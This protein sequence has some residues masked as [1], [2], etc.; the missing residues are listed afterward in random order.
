[1]PFPHPFP[2]FAASVEALGL[3]LTAGEIR[4]IAHH[5]STA[6]SP[7]RGSGAGREAGKNAVVAIEYPHFAR[8]VLEASTV[9][10][11]TGSGADDWGKQSSSEGAWW[12]VIPQTAQKCQK[13]YKRA[14]SRSKFL[15]SLKSKMKKKGDGS[16]IESKHFKKIISSARIKLKKDDLEDL[17]NLLGGE[18][19]VDWKAFMKVFKAKLAEGDKEDKESD[20]DDDDSDGGSS[21]DDGSS[22]SDGSGS[23]SSGSS[24]KGSDD[25]SSAPSGLLYMFA[26]AM[27]RQS[28]PRSWLDH[29]CHIFS[30]SDKDERGYLRGSAFH[31][32]CGKV[33]V[34]VSK[35]QFKTLAKDLDR[36][37]DGNVSYIEIL[38][39]LLKSLKNGGAGG[40]TFLGDEREI[41][42]KILDAMGENP[43]ARRRWLSKLRKHFFGL[44]NFRSGTM[45]GPKLIGVLRD[46]GV[47]LSRGEE[48]RLL[49]LLATMDDQNEGDPEDVGG[50]VSYRELLR[51]CA[52]NA[53]KWY[54]QDVDLAETLRRALRDKMRK[55]SFVVNLKAAFEEFDENGDGVVS[56]R[57]FEKACKKLGMRLESADS[58][59]L[60]EIL[61]LDGS[62]NISYQDF[63]TFFNNSSGKSSWYECEP[64]I[65][66]KMKSSVIK[67]KKGA[68]AV[69]TFRDESVSCD[70]DSNGFCDVRDLRKNILR[71][72]KVKLSEKVRRIFF[73]PCLFLPFLL[74][75]NVFTFSSAAANSFFSLPLSR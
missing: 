73:C 48:G 33:G 67:N 57:E 28:D 72:I 49:E 71:T 17:V 19:A 21:S 24:S 20:S 75:H 65:A 58:R 11:F 66:R 16:E 39:S 7:T 54:E 10:R 29:A 25:S 9:N 23:S 41:A 69:F 32:L 44:D 74:H 30:E 64:E 60:M 4:A 38:S 34:K 27:M 68:Q 1:M 12:E 47:R 22:G 42:E 50:S 13:A 18:D 61:D 53:G 6:E 70:E 31:H 45:P 52:N 2:S 8:F 35:K 43:G 56:K 51:F 37:A 14:K 36:D 3:V 55:K 40:K 26:K 46:L 59:K 15:K 63:V 62:G 5:F